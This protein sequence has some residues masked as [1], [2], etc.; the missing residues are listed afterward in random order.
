VVTKLPKLT[1]LITLPK[2][3][4]LDVPAAGKVFTATFHNED[5]KTINADVGTGVNGDAG[6]RAGNY[7]VAVCPANTTDKACLAKAI[8]NFGFLS[9]TIPTGKNMTIKVAVRS[10]IKTMKFD[11]KIDGISV[12]LQK[13]I[14]G[15]PY[16]VTLSGTSKSLRSR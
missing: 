11:P 14:E 13:R 2:S 6:S 4:I 5:A 12:Y 15:L 8:N 9:V 3:G 16:P 10:T 1:L 7:G